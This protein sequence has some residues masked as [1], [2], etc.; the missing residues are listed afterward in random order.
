META[1]LSQ[2]LS[3]LFPIRNLKKSCISSKNLTILFY[4]FFV[5]NPILRKDLFF[6]HLSNMHDSASK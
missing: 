6:L 5:Y 2:A 4:H 3:F 1:G